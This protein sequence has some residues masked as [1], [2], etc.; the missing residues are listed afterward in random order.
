MKNDEGFFAN[1][2]EYTKIIPKNY[3]PKFKIVFYE[4]FTRHSLIDNNNMPLYAFV[5]CTFDCYSLQLKTERGMLPPGQ[6][7]LPF[8]AYQ[9]IHFISTQL[10]S[11]QIASL[12]LDSNMVNGDW[13]I[14]VIGNSGVD[15]DEFPPRKA[16]WCNAWSKNMVWFIICQKNVNEQ[17][18]LIS[19]NIE[20]PYDAKNFSLRIDDNLNALLHCDWNDKS[21]VFFKFT[22]NLLILK[23]TIDGIENEEQNEIVA[24]DENELYIAAVSSNEC[25]SR[26]LAGSTIIKCFACRKAT[27]IPPWGLP[28]NFGL[29]VNSSSISDAIDSL[30]NARRLSISNIRQR[31][32]IAKDV[33]K[34]CEQHANEILKNFEQTIIER[35]A[36]VLIAV[37][38]AKKIQIELWKAC[39]AVSKSEKQITKA[40][41]QVITDLEKK[42]NEIAI[43]EQLKVKF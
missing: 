11:T 23:D 22:K 21:A 29:R 9:N 20:A 18:Q 8:I 36:T 12:L 27:T 19:V 15:N 24:S 28:I 38:L 42:I 30:E 32:K 39:D 3:T 2:L 5:Y 34:N 33:S 41:D 40:A 6:W 10:D 17:Q 26:I 1:E 7:E 37:P 13:N 31:C 14:R 25:I 43:D 16:V 35:I 4:R